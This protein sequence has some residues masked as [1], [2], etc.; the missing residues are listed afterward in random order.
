MNDLVTIPKTF[1]AR[2]NFW[3]FFGIA[4]RILDHAGA[5]L[6]F[7][8]LK[9]FKLKE[10]I[11]VFKD[12]ARTQPLLNIKARQI[13]DIAATYDVTD[14]ATGAPL[15]ALRR[16]GLRSILKDQW[17]ILD[18]YGEV[19]GNIHEDSMLLALLRRFLSNL[20]AQDYHFFMGEQMVG[21]AKGSWNP[22][23]VKYYV[24]FTHDSQNLLDPRMGLAAMVMLMTIEGKQ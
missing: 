9:A 8:K 15:G 1:V 10:D 6:Y 20:I 12:E 19:I 21:L 13:L 2:R 18:P 3:N 14:V 23:L 17:D 11:T 24:D 22:F 4:C 7:V 5:L 16:R